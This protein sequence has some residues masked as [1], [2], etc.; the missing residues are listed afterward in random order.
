MDSGT[1]AD[2]AKN[3]TQSFTSYSNTTGSQTKSYS[4]AKNQTSSAASGT[5]QTDL[6]LL[7]VMIRAAPQELEG[8]R[9][10][11]R[12]AIDCN[13]KKVSESV[14][15]LLLQLHTNVDFE[16]RSRISEFEN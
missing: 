5:T 13:D 6:D 4:F 16:L 2:Y 14:A 10:L 3:A 15:A 8:I 11:W 1:Q 7:E 12:I 9:G